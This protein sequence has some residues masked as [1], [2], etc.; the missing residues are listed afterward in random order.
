MDST[1]N[2]HREAWAFSPVT[3]DLKGTIVTFKLARTLLIVVA[4]LALAGGNAFAAILACAPGS[5]Q[6][7]MVLDSCTIGDKT[8]S[9]FASQFTAI[10]GGDNFQVPVMPSAAGITVTPIA[11]PNYGFTFNF[12]GT[13]HDVSYYQTLTLD[14]AYL[15]TVGQ[16]YNITS[17]YTQ[18]GGGEAVS[19]GGQVGA[20]V[21]VDKDLCLGAAFNT[22]DTY[23]TTTCTAGTSVPGVANQ[24]SFSLGNYED[25]RTG[26][27]TLASGQRVL[28]VSDYIHIFGGT[29][30]TGG[31]TAAIV[32]TTNEF[33]QSP[34]GVPEPATFLLLGSALLGL[35]ALRRK[36]V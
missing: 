10:T 6:S 15:V 9:N 14:I 31:Q 26:T 8:F 27:L 13:S 16:G 4:L 24:S 7:Y 12:T 33:L 3:I 22:V 11:G 1:T 19:P 5:L 29:V 20:Y 21:T 23:A 2:S 25:I 18:A 36:R 28:G 35:G 17:V 34:T 32:F 30:N